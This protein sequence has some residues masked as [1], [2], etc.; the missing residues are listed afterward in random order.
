[1]SRLHACHC[2]SSESSAQSPQHTDQNKKHP[3]IEGGTGEDKSY[4]LTWQLICGCA[5]YLD[6]TPHVLHTI[7]HMGDLQIFP[8]MLHSHLNHSSA[9]L[10]SQLSH[11]KKLEQNGDMLRRGRLQWHA[12]RVGDSSGSRNALL[13]HLSAISS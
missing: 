11:L 1:M 4:E 3:L 6:R 2:P 9:H 7:K 12:D 5:R 10:N 8:S 13:C